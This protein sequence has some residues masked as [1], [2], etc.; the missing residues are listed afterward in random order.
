MKPANE[1]AG[2][3]SPRARSSRLARLSR[4]EWTLIVLGLGV[5]V[6]LAIG[7]L[8]LVHQ[9]TRSKSSCGGQ[10]EARTSQPRS[11]VQGP[12]NAL[13]LLTRT[14]RCQ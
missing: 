7:G 3:S 10:I 2:T 6:A 9:F 1:T 13:Q 5:W 4:R 14:G 12:R 11:Q 8:W